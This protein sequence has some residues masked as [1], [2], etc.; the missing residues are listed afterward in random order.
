MNQ[1]F[2]TQNN[3]LVGLTLPSGCVNKQLTGVSNLMEFSTFVN[4]LELDLK[5]IVKPLCMH[6]RELMKSAHVFIEEYLLYIIS[7]KNSIS[8]RIQGKCKRKDFNKSNTLF[9]ISLLFDYSENPKLTF[10]LTQK[11]N[12]FYQLDNLV[13]Y[14]RDHFPGYV[15]ILKSEY[16]YK[17]GKSKKLED[18]VKKFGVLL[19][20]SFDLVCY[21]KTADH[22]KVERELHQIFKDDRINGEWFRMDENCWDIL[23]KYCEAHSYKIIYPNCDIKTGQT[24]E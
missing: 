3:T 13:K 11:V 5:S 18:R 14:S 23:Y 6:D 10:T 12:K 9:S 15:Y 20:F 16:G 17:I 4:R 19:P 2:I 8:E 22:G 1:N 7:C 24:F 21:I